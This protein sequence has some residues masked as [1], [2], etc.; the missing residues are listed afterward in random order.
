MKIEDRIYSS[1]KSFIK[2]EPQRH[3]EHRERE[4]ERENRD[5]SE[6]FRIAIYQI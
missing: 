4:N 3:R 2:N 1:P 5:F 6:S